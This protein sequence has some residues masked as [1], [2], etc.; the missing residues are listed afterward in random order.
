VSIVAVP[1]IARADGLYLFDS[2]GNLADE[3]LLNPDPTASSLFSYGPGT[4]RAPYPI[5]D[6]QLEL[7]ANDS[8]VHAYV[9]DHNR[10]HADN[11]LDSV[12]DLGGDGYDYQG[13]IE[14][15]RCPQGNTCMWTLTGWANQGRSF[16]VQREFY[17]G[18]L[19]LGLFYLPFISN[20]FGI[21]KPGGCPGDPAFSHPRTGI[22]DQLQ[23]AV[24]E[25]IMGSSSISSI[26]DETESASWETGRAMCKR[27]G[28]TSGGICGHSDTYDFVDLIRLHF[29]AHITPKTPSWCTTTAE[30]LD[31][32]SVGLDF[33]GYN[34][35]CSAL[36]GSYRATADVWL[37]PAEGTT[38]N[39]YQFQVSEVGSYYSVNSYTGL[40]AT[41][42]LN[43]L[44]G[45]FEKSNPAV[46]LRN[47][48]ILKVGHSLCCNGPSSD[49]NWATDCTTDG[50]N[51]NDFHAGVAYFKSHRPDR[52]Q[53]GLDIDDGTSALA[54]Y[55]QPFNQL[56]SDD[57][58]GLLLLW[59]SR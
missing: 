52:V 37:Q 12:S 39:F 11:A 51:E 19:D 28:I 14:G 23:S 6:N 25:G 50:T 54:N 15:F 56:S 2:N 26:S 27:L 43:Q 8:D 1:A 7:I 24:D 55:F 42:M 36:S 21:D 45:Q 13:G 58:T 29:D 31:I 47:G 40:G 33:G 59:G 57:H 4:N 46:M 41:T 18:E 30:I 22:Q 34:A 10:R 9:F 20:R 35:I 32:L 16:I 5:T 3:Y 49:P 38:N 17:T 48:F 53:L 44:K